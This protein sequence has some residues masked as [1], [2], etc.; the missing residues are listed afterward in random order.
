[1][2]GRG[3][4]EDAGR[5]RIVHGWG[6]ERCGAEQPKAS[7]FTYCSACS[8]SPREEINLFQSH[9]RHHPVNPALLP[10]LQLALSILHPEH[11]HRT[12]SRGDRLHREGIWLLF[13][14]V[15]SPGPSPS[16]MSAGGDFG[17]PL[18]KFKLVFLG[19]QSGK[20]QDH[21]KYR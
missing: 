11:T 3:E 7:L 1:M 21:H 2:S 20:C 16:I 9:C 10:L 15:L 8:A 12:K 13:S 5:R 17:N 19:E 6:G 18:R 14:L 4:K